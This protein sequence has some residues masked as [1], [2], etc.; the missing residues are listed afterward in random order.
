MEEQKVNH[1]QVREGF[2]SRLGVLAATL[3]SAVGLGN[4]WKFP[5]VTGQNGGAAFIII[6]LLCILFVGLPIMISEFIIGRKC[7]ANAI[8]SFRTLAPKKPWYMVGVSGVLSS[9]LIL[10]F[11]STV[12][13][14]VF[15]YVS[16]AA[17]GVFKGATPEKAGEIFTTLSTGIQEPLF[18]QF[19][20]IIVVSAVIMAGVQKGIEKVTKTLMPVLF[21]LLII[22]DI[23]ALSLPGAMEGVKFLFQPDFSKITGATILAAL[24]LAFFK[25]S[26]GMGTMMTYGS[27]IGDE[28]NLPKTALKVALSDTLVSILAGLAVFPAVFA[29]GFQPDGGPKLLFI[30]I[31]MVFRS[32]PMGNLF[33]VLFFILVS[34]A[35]TTASISMLEVPVAYFTETFHWSRRK[36]TML[37]SAGV[38]ALGVLATLSQSPEALASFKILGKNIFDLLDFMTSNLLLPLGG[39]F[40]ALFVG[41]KLKFEMI[42]EEGSNKGVLANKRILQLYYCIVKYITPIVVLIVLINSLI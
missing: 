23:K 30:T 18:W 1:K 32:M 6:Y 10:G 3:G 27:Y 22:C 37:S 26:V 2:G 19:I 12:A 20:V 21:V 40:I 25:L 14:W 42:Y 5:V 41:W 8:T 28:E 4:I 31:P 34:I 24:G 39:I 13:G 16:K 36:A 29:F 9:F 11:Y 17:L 38:L 7:K 35:A 33:L 15:S